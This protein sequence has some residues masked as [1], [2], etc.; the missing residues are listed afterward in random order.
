MLLDD[1][2]RR[3]EAA[4]MASRIRRA[5]FDEAYD[6]RDFDF[7]YNPEIPKAE[8]WQLAA[9]RYL[10]EHPSV[11]VCGPTGVGKTFFAQALG[12]AACR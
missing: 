10:E 4:G 11:L 9:R 5:R 6:L 3:R 1:E 12:V 8:L 7:S 2:L